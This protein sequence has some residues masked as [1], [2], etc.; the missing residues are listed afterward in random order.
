MAVRRAL[1][2]VTPLH[3]PSF[4][5][6]WI[7]RSVSGVGSQLTIVAVMFQVWQRTHSTVWTGAVG[8]A[9][10]VPVIALGLFAGSHVDRVDRRRLYLITT[11]GQA[12]CSALLAAQ[13][14]FG[15]LP[16]IGVLAL[17]AA[18]G[19]FIATGGPAARTFIPRLL[20]PAQVA[21][22]LA[23]D[24]ISFQA[25]MLLGPALGGLAIGAFGVGGCYLI[26][27]A[28]FAVGFYGAF[29]LPA[30]LPEGGTARPGARGVVDGLSFLVHNPPVRA[31][32]LTDLATTL[33]SFP[34]SLFPL[35]NAERF[36][37]NP[38]TFGLFLTAIA[39]GGTIA[40]TFAGTFTRIDRPGTTM[41]VG[42]A[43]WG[44][45]LALFGA[46]PNAWAGLG[47]LVIAGAA[48]TVAVVSRGTIAQLSTPDALRGR[49]AAAEQVVGQAGPDIG[50]LR[51][52]LIA[53]ATSSVTALVSGGLLCVAAVTAIAATTPAVRRFTPAT[54]PAEL[55][56]AT[57]NERFGGSARLSRSSH[58]LTV[59]TT[60][61]TGTLT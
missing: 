59:K 58:G 11:T 20:P 36:G 10:A 17:V 13:G 50:N 24:R 60:A 39:I 54:L 18:Q 25:S 53:H 57:S 34:I 9:Q 51:A 29:G 1:V 46:V 47:L 30:M 28:T 33:L 49:V 52:G 23:L 42:S 7:G 6:L 55:E 40:S 3:Q 48:D 43:T 61:P 44:I 2:D 32:L 38:R 19:C 37:N 31:A 35:I 27:A 4:R 41:L 56:P 12:A 21:A 22:G 8:V 15:H 16:A 45:A 26:D 14:L 5:R